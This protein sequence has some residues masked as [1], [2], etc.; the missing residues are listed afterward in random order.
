[1]HSYLHDTPK[2]SK[3][4]YSS[5][6]SGKYV[7]SLCYSNVESVSFACLSVDLVTNVNYILARK[8][9]YK[10]WNLEYHGYLMAERYGHR[11]GTMYTCVDGDP[12]TL[13]GGHTNKNSKLF[14]SVEIPCSSL[15]CPPYVEGREL[16]CSVCS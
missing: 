2:H 9:C 15:K 3:C 10:G 5:N 11:A 7:Y 16:V 4:C 8:T 6:I 1:M 12:D 13:H 14:Y